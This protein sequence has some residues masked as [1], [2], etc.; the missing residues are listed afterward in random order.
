MKRKLYYLIELFA[1]LFVTGCEDLEDTYDE[2]TGGGMNRYLGKCGN[3]EV[4]AGWERLRVVWKNNLDVGVKHTKITWKSENDDEAF[5]RYVERGNVVD[6][7]DLMDTIYLEGLEDATYEVTV[8]NVAADSTES[9]STTL[10]ARP[11]TTEHEDLRTFT[12]GITNFFPLEDKLVVILDNDNENLLGVTLT[13]WGTD[14]QEHVWDVKEGMADSIEIIPGMPEYGYLARDYIR[15][16]PENAGYGIDFSK[17]LVIHREGRLSACFDNVPFAGDTLSM[18]DRVLSVGFSQWLNTHYG[19][20]YESELENIETVEFDY[21]MSTF[22]DLFYLPNLKKVTLGKNRFMAD[23]HRDENLSVTD[24]YMGLKA[25]QILQETRGITIERYNSQYFN[26]ECESDMLMPGMTLYE[27]LQMTGFW[28]SM[29]EYAS[30]ENMA[31]MPVYTPFN[32]DEWEVTCVTDTLYSD[33]KTNGARW[34]LDDDPTTYF[35]PGQMLGVTVLEVEIDMKEGRTIHGFKVSQP[36]RATS[37]DDEVTRE[38]T[39]LIPSLEIEVSE[40]GFN[41]EP[42][43][44]DEG[45]ITIGD[46]IGEI[47]FIEIPEELQSRNVRYIRLSMANRHTGEITDASGEHVPTYS[48]RL[49]DV[50]PY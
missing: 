2:F 19:P 47:T 11:Y 15:L 39:Y 28:L 49:G 6:A 40:D 45:S 36:L 16:L 14:G 27:A 4:Q 23:G 7:E 41:W 25:L 46:A 43:T 24:D 35:E 12:R 20:D 38:L 37:S 30:G 29:S 31:A 32:S 1:A 5:V 18:T 21:D 22:Q 26:T 48:L 17:P 42:A 8:T 44:Y 50:V 33:K 34:L 10:Y 9:L 3:V 13:F